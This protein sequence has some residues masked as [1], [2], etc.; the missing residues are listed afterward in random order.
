MFGT[1]LGDLR[2]NNGRTVALVGVSCVVIVVLLLSDQEVDGFLQGGDNGVV[3]DLAHVGDHGLGR[4]SL[5]FGQWHDAERY[6]VPMSLPWRLSWVG[7]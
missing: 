3:V 2:A 6:C 7:S 5:F 4:G 1:N